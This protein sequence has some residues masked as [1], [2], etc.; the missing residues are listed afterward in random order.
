MVARTWFSAYL[1][2]E[3]WNNKKKFYDS[4]QSL[5]RSVEG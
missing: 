3:K 4:V 5:E 1:D 2:Y